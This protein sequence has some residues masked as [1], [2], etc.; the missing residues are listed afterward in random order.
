MQRKTER[1][2]PKSLISK[3]KKKEKTDKNEQ[4]EQE[5]PYIGNCTNKMQT[6]YMA[7]KVNKLKL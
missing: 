7:V 2:S 5:C 6:M 4:Q 3:A 1:Y